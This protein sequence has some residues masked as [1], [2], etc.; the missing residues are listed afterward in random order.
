MRSAVVV[1]V[2]D[3]VPKYSPVRSVGFK[4][5]DLLKSFLGF[6]G[7]VVVVKVNGEGGWASRRDRRLRQFQ[8]RC[9]ASIQVVVG[10]VTRWERGS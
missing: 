2:S 7:H 9:A 4:L 6:R 8:Q 1:L 10:Q 5:R 3:M